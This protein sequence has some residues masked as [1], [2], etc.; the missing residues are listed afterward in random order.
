MVC[1]I[2]DF[3]NH[4]TAK[5]STDTAV[6]VMRLGVFDYLIKPFRPEEISLVIMRA[7]GQRK[8]YNEILYLRQQLAERY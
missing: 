7:L 1:A 3:L 4:I 5:G 6:E 2:T 8:L